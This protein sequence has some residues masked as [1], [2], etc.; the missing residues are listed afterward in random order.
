MSMDYKSI[1][2]RVGLEI[3]QQ[4]DTKH[5]LFCKCPNTMRQDEPEIFFKRRLRPSQSE[6]GEV[7]PAALFEFQRGKTFL[8]EAYRDSTCLV[9]ADSI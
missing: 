3:H 5:K 9:E 4:L 8:Y 7:D 2:L 6:L 1:G